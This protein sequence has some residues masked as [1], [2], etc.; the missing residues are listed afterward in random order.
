M[1]TDLSTFSK[2]CNG[3]NCGSIYRSS[4][5]YIYFDD[6]GSE[7]SGLLLNI[8]RNGGTLKPNGLREIRNSYKC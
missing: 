6:G 1:K 7:A 4:E 8:S 2:Q 3:N 5:N